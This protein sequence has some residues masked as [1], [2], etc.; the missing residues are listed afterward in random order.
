M[1]A[2]LTT[3]APTPAP[4]P[5]ATGPVRRTRSIPPTRRRAGAALVAVMGAVA[6]TEWHV[7]F[8][9]R[10]TVPLVI[11]AVA[12]VVVTLAAGSPRRPLVVTG[13]TS[14][15][16]LVVVLAGVGRDASPA[17]LV[18]GLLHGWSRILST[19]LEVPTTEGRILFPAAVVWVA[20]LMGA[21]AALR[22]RTRP[23]V[24]V[25]PPLLAYLV[26][27]PFGAG[28]GNLAS[29]VVLLMVGLVTMRVL[30]PPTLT[31]D[32][33]NA[34]PG[35]GGPTPTSAQRPV[36]VVGAVTFVAVA[37]GLGVGAG[38]GLPP[39]G[40]DHPYDPRAD[41]APPLEDVA[42]I[43]PLSLLAGWALDRDDP[44]LFTAEGPVADRWRLA[45]LDRYDPA[46]GW[47]SRSSYVAAGSRVPAPDVPDTAA[48]PGSAQ[49]REV[50]IDELAGVWLPTT[51]RPTGVDGL[52]AHV[53]PA[54]TMLVHGPGLAPGRRYHLTSDPGTALDDCT[55]AT[56]P[57]RPPDPDVGSTIS[58]E[59]LSYAT[60]ITRG[61]TSACEQA[62]RI[63]AYL[64][65]DNFA[66]SAEAP[67]G[68]T[69][70]R[71]A[72]L[73]TPAGNGDG[74]SDGEGGG[75][76]PDP[77]S[78]T[79]EQFA[80]AFALLARASGLEVRVAVGFRSGESVGDAQRVHA[81]DA[82]AWAE[83]RFP[84][85]G[86]VAFDPTPGS[87]DD[88]ESAELTIPPVP[89]A[90]TTTSGPVTTVPTATTLP[91]TTTTDDPGGSCTGDDCAEAGALPLWLAAGLL[92]VVPVGGLLLAIALVRRQRRSARRQRSAAADRVIGAWR[93]C[94]VELRAGG[95]PLDPANTV[96]DYVTHT[97]EVLGP[98]LAFEL[99]SVATLANRALFRGEASDDD[100]ALAW[101]ATD[102][103]TAALAKERSAPGRV[104]H[105]LDVRA[106]VRA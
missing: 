78:G 72:D 11:A 85:R 49:E 83:V 31:D 42:T 94:L 103:L 25:V 40:D 81:S 88:P 28:G 50:T 61:S 15:V 17:G 26:A 52:D 80:T 30:S 86:W 62:Q 33:A 44:V 67:S 63:E 38:L 105:A 46:T 101:R 23:A 5:A 68:A 14:L 75:D 91:T 74:G 34:G 6:A 12:S 66:F 89:P 27:L 37:A 19:T 71:I 51:G 41:Q 24:A 87:G 4:A 77:K 99:D 16:V 69:M 32:A 2:T 1:T 36:R 39:A 10:P 82:L 20:G 60:A 56:A 97:S 57:V 79:S 73:L 65:S 96:S 21:E 22:L 92:L 58:V 47:S 53:D 13:A 45:V 104:L 106:L 70:A 43:D 29:A 102:R 90:P 3:P 55:G 7:V 35:A 54:T 9:A 59:V 98:R 48:A 64:R 84:E 76:P 100:A 18:D 8:G 95:L 93:Q